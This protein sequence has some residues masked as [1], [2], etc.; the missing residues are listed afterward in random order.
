[1]D[2]AFQVEGVRWA[3]SVVDAEL[4]AAKLRELARQ[5]ERDGG[6]NEHDAM[7]LIDAF[8]GTVLEL[9]EYLSPAL[10]AA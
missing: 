10:G 5:I 4:V 1:M 7:A 2:A 6:M 8:E 9:A 3:A